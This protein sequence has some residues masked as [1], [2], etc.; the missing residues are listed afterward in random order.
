MARGAT[1][2]KEEIK[3]CH[4]LK[5]EGRKVPEICDLMKRTPPTVRKMLRMAPQDALQTATERAAEPEV[6]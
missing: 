5:A 3:R 6:V 2:Q 1:I 4:E